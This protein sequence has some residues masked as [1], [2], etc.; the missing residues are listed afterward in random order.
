MTK[1][2]Y[3]MQNATKQLHTVAIMACQMV[4]RVSSAIGGAWYVGMPMLLLVHAI[5]VVEVA[6]GLGGQ[7]VP[8]SRRGASLVAS[9]VCGF[10]WIV[11][12]MVSHGYGPDDQC[13]C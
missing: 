3:V 12:I 10:A 7:D 13:D 5:G 2:V 11:F 1:R 9:F 4:G 8:C 6:L